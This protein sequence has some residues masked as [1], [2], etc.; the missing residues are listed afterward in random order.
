MG[1]IKTCLRYVPDITG[2]DPLS[3]VELAGGGS[4]SEKLQKARCL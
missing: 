3:L 4:N 1:R 2:L